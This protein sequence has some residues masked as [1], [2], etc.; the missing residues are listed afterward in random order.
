MTKTIRK[1]E[2]AVNPVIAMILM[3]AITVVLAA[4][5][6]VMV[7]GL[8]GTEHPCI[9]GGEGYHCQPP[10]SLHYVNG[11]LA[12]FSWTDT[13]TVVNLGSNGTYFFRGTIQGLADG[14]AYSIAYYVDNDGAYVFVSYREG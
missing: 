4:V 1:N 5:L 6:Y 2:D 12:S 9:G 14:K 3:V 11:T 7:S 13:G 10:S 8:I